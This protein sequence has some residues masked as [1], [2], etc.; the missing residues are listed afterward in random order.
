MGPGL[1]TLIHA[2][3]VGINVKKNTQMYVNL[4]Q[5]NQKSQYHSRRKKSHEYKQSQY[6]LLKRVS[7]RP[8]LQESLYS[9]QPSSSCEDHSYGIKN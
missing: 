5:I 4:K 1:A 3:A 9:C 2:R 6:F 8:L 7:N